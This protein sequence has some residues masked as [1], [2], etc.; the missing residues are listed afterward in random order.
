MFARHALRL[1]TIAVLLA[2]C[3]GDS[4]GPSGQSGP[5]VLSSINGATAPSG[6]V[7]ST[8]SIEGQN[9]GDSQGSSQVLFSDGV[10]GTI[11][12]VIASA[13]DWTNTFIVTTVPS[14]AATGDVVV[15]T[16]LGT[17]NALTFTITS[18]AAFSPS[19]IS[20][21]STSA[22]PA[23]VSGQATAYAQ[24]EG[25]ST[26]RAVYSVGGADAANAPV[27]TVHYAIVDGSGNLSGW[28]ATA[29]LPVGLAF[30]RLTVATPTNSRVT[31]LGHL[32]V[33]GGATDAGG[34]PTATVYRG[35]LAADGT[36]SAWSQVAALPAPLHSMG[37]VIFQGE[38]Y[39]FG[40]ATTGNAPVATV[41]SSRIEAAG[42]LGAWQ[43]QAGLPF[44]RSYF[45][46]GTF[47]GY[48]YTFGG[49]S[50]TVAP[51]S[52]S[53]ASSA[54]NDVSYAKIDVRTGDITTAGWTTNSS[55]LTKTTSK[56]TAVVAGG[57]V[58]ITAG[59]YNGAL[60]GSTEQTYAQLNAD[61]SV[62]SFSG[63]TGSNTIASLGGGNLFNHSA[64]GYTDGNGVFHVL[65][66]GGD[67]VNSPST[68]HTGVFFY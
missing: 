32:Y 28:T 4:T 64:T 49:D 30:H 68:K 3:G 63:A 17:S 65:V 12:A 27:S 62:G 14:G 44:A 10:G 16:G 56:H 13:G 9:F 36:I 34:A 46:Y 50:G 1:T 51:N 15:Q 18:A 21:T 45:G 26:T 38:L 61:G 6:P 24:L 52:G 22:L 25:Q 31:S 53:L 67:D 59:L 29:S 55:S 41:Y 33:L 66:A 20:W 48:L 47:G 54:I 37:A 5:P 8:V 43:S 11:P 60:T 57:N 40:G 58:L 39:V 35:D 19:T 23:G 42:T 7:G 2:A